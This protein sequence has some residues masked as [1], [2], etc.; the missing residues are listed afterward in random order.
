[1]NSQ[2]S[3]LT[4]VKENEPTMTIIETPLLIGSVQKGTEVKYNGK[5]QDGSNF[6]GKVVDYN[7]TT[8]NGNGRVSFH[9]EEYTTTKTS[10][11]SPNELLNLI[12]NQMNNVLRF[13]VFPH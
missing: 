13:S 4:I 6:V 10:G 11:I 12:N 9:K 5:L 2:D 1:M 8:E 3:N 7:D